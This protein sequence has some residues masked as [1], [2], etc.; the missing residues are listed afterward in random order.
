MYQVG[1][2]L[3]LFYRVDGAAD[4]QTLTQAQVTILDI[5]PNGLPQQLL[6][7]PRP[8]GQTL[9]LDGTVS[10]PL[11]TEAFVIQAQ[12]AGMQDQSQ[13]SIQVIAAPGCM[14]ACDCPTEQMCNASGQCQIGMSAVYC[15]DQGPCPAGSPC[16]HVTGGFSNCMGGP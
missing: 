11:G 12:A 9:G 10:P 7:G 14:T 5:P 16:Q 8:A 2:L 3:S 13:C 15:C 4:G 1:E 6:S